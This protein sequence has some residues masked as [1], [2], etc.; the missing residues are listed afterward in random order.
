MDGFASGESRERRPI[1]VDASRKKRGG[2]WGHCANAW[3]RSWKTTRNGDFGG[4][5]SARP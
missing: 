2:R 5:S 3:G 4:S 1:G